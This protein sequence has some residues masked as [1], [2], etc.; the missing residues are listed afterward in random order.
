MKKKI[1]SDIGA[2]QAS[3]FQVA[4]TTS[5]PKQKHWDDK[6]YVCQAFAT[7]LEER[8]QL[9]KTISEGETS[10]VVSTLCDHIAFPDN[11]L[12]VCR[13]LSSGPQQSDITWLAYMHAEAIPR[14]KKTN[15]L[16]KD[17]LC[18]EIKFCE[19]WVDEEEAAVN[20][21]KKVEPVFF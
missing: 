19:P 5:D 9:R 15:K 21:A 14:R 17:Q 10:R 6:C 18:E 16:F 12:P 1:C 13:E 8:L 7:E 4:L 3:H 20:E 11:L 2:G